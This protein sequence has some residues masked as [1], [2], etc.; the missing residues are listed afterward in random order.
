MDAFIS[1]AV[2]IVYF[3]ACL[4]IPFSQRNQIHLEYDVTAHISG[5]LCLCL[6][7]QDFHEKALELCGDVHGGVDVVE[8]G[9]LAAG[10]RERLESGVPSKVVFCHNDLQAS[11]WAPARHVPV[12]AIYWGV[13]RSRPNG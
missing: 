9:A 6:C 3:C 7:G 5:R 1:T 2:K 13:A 11:T 12:K 10:L 8:L 4:A